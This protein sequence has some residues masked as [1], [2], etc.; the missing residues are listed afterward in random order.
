MAYSQIQK[1][2]YREV[3]KAKRQGLI[4]IP[5]KCEECGRMRRIHGHHED[6]NKPLDIM[7]LCI[8]CHFKKHWGIR[9]KKRFRKGKMLLKP[10]D[11][12]VNF[13]LSGP[14]LKEFRINNKLS[15]QDFVLLANICANEEEILKIENRR[16]NLVNYIWVYKLCEKYSIST[17]LFNT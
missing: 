3:V 8:S 10:D 2:A 16:K 11:P 6:Y 13:R 7:W 17:N 15:V 12:C 14:K 1:M 9:S 5:A 4:T